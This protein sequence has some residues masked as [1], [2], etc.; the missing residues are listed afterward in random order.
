MSLVGLC[1]RGR[2]RRLLTEASVPSEQPPPK[3]SGPD[4]ASGSRYS[5]ASVGRWAGAGAGGRAGR[6][7]GRS[8]RAGAGAGWV[9]GT[10][11]RPPRDPPASDRPTLYPSVPPPSPGGREANSLAGGTPHLRGRGPHMAGCACLSIGAHGW[12]TETATET[13]SMSQK[14][15]PNNSAQGS[16]FKWCAHSPLTGLFNG[17]STCSQESPREPPVK[18]SWEQVNSLCPW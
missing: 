11:R 3:A 17:K 14:S 2:G 9:A 15:C 12:A 8:V 7:G 13:P 10:L 5:G 16:L 18:N 6:A 1:R 4:G